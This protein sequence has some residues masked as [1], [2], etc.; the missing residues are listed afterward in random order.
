M[1]IAL[2]TI[3]DES[4]REI[5]DR[6]LPSMRRYADTFG[7]EF[8]NIPPG[9]S[10]RPPAWGKIHRIREV[11]RSGFDHCFYVD[12]DTIF[13][14]FD[15]DI[16]DHVT[17]AKDLHLCWHSSD[18]SESYAAIQG[19]FNTGVMLWRNCAWSIDFLDEIWRQTDFIH[20]MWWE[21]AA[22]LHLL[23]YRKAL[24]QATDEP[25]S[26]RAAHLGHLPVDWNAVVGYTAAPDPIIR[27]FAGRPKTRRLADLDRELAFQPMRETLSP[28]ARHVLARQ[29]NLMAH[30]AQQAEEQVLQAQEISQQALQ[31]MRSAQDA[32]E[33]AAHRTT[34]AEGR[35][36]D[37]AHQ[38]RITKGEAEEAAQRMR[39]AQREAETAAQEMRIAHG[40]AEE[41]TQQA[42]IAEGRA[43]QATR[44][45]GI[46]EER[47]KEAERQTE[48]ARGETQQALAE[49]DAL[50]RSPARLASAW[51]H[52]VRSKFGVRT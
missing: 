4:F 28:Q 2:L 13:V 37:A 12:A 18:N 14:R 5:A 41:A 26:A 19:H 16:R 46:A 17:P 50:L 27:H 7:L 33:Q 39:G 52:A 43:E 42:R 35:A 51:W 36:Q 6:T 32:A 9:L 24:G 29:L 15:A 21:Q 47:V 44:Q 40:R 38:M 31:H 30:Q 8:L 11:L 49:H 45:A 3:S 10:D 25:D 34:A 20:H 23:G 48:V 22:L 1:K